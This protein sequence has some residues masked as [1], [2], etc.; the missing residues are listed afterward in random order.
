M[1]VSGLFLEAVAVGEMGIVMAARLS[2]DYNQDFEDPDEMSYLFYISMLPM[3]PAPFTQNG[4]ATAQQEQRPAPAE[5]HQQ[6][7]LSGQ[8]A[9]MEQI[10]AAP[11]D[12]RAV[13]IPEGTPQH[14]EDNR[15]GG[16]R[17]RGRG[18]GGGRGFGRGNQGYSRGS[19][20][21]RG[22]GDRGGDKGQ[23]GGDHGRGERKYDDRRED[24]RD[25]RKYEDKGDKPRGG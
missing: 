18:R 12:P 5:Q 7:A 22:R 8:A 1:F 25:D 16:E 20:G 17:G 10:S 23:R 3:Q 4:P 11:V 13:R 14:R 24:R 6:P 21:S 19:R 15:W 9:P 2:C